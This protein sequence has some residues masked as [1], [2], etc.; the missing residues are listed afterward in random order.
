MQSLDYESSSTHELVLSVSNMVPLEGLPFDDPSSSATVSIVVINENEAPRFYADPILVKV[1]ESIV[2]GTV[3]VQNIAHDPDNA[4]L[5]L[6]DQNVSHEV[7]RRFC[8]T[9]VSSVLLCLH[10]TLGL[11]S[12]TTQRSGL[13]LTVTLERSQ[14]DK[15]STSDRRTS[16]TTFTVPWLKYLML[17]S[18]KAVRSWHQEGLMVASSNS[19]SEVA[20]LHVWRHWT[21][22]S[23]SPYCPLSS[24]VDIDGISTAGTLEISLIETNDHS[25]QLFPLS[26]TMCSNRDTPGI[27][28]SATDEDMPPHSAP[29]TFSIPFTANWSVSQING[30]MLQ[31]MG[32]SQHSHFVI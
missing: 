12:A 4:R 3:I 2:P 21:E 29:F 9:S 10:L 28:L 30:R 24:F 22:K 23:D 7:T 27:L 17:V 25:P 11:R 31:S 32:A 26:A 5:R 13:P 8:V 18:H 1:P 14:P 16:R 6:V 15:L 20:C 19:F